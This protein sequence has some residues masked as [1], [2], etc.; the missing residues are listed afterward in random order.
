MGTWT[1]DTPWRQG[2]LISR[3]DLLDLG[4]SVEG[5]HVFGVVVSHD[6]DLANDDLCLEPDV[7]IVLIRSLDEVD[8]NC[9]FGK[10]PRRLHFHFK[11]ED[12]KEVAFEAVAKDRRT[13][14]KSQLADCTPCPSHRLESKGLDIL[15]RWLACRYRR[16]ALPDALMQRLR[17]PL[18]LIKKLMKKSASSIVGIWIAFDPDDVADENTV[19][20]L[21]FYFVYSTDK[22]SD[23]ATQAENVAR[24]ITEYFGTRSEVDDTQ[25]GLFLGRCIAV[26]EDGFTLRDMRRTVEL[27]LE[28]LSY[29][30]AEPGPM[31]P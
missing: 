17:K 19:Y 23:A 24:R 13:V 30:N 26:A 27:K 4:T 29:R 3:E 20:E 8:H 14:Q 15:Q 11:G 25:S 22:E 7:D 12:D 10:S 16:Q 21:E 28:Y 31:V 6:C 5:G 1:R 9:T 2:S 18:D